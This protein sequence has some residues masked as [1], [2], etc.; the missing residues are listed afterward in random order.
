MNVDPMQGRSGL[1]VC[2]QVNSYTA[3]LGIAMEKI[4]GADASLKEFYS[5]FHWTSL[6]S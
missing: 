3:E 5:P 2:Y 1:T 4:N 6:Y